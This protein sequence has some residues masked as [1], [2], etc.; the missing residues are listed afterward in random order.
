VVLPSLLKTRSNHFIQA[1]RKHMDTSLKE[2]QK[3]MIQKLLNRFLGKLTSLKWAILKSN[4]TS[5]A[6]HT[7]SYLYQKVQIPNDQTWRAY[8]NSRIQRLLVQ[9]HRVRGLVGAD[10]FPGKERI[11][12]SSH[13]YKSIPY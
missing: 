7:T 8:Q 4:I 1:M 12:L 2:R 9:D 10:R 3:L 11:H 5:L 13:S 6:R